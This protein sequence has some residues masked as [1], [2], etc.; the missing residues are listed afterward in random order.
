MKRTIKVHKKQPANHLIKKVYIIETANAT[1]II[2]KAKY[3][4]S[5]RSEKYYCKTDTS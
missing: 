4:A 5:L 3:R 1:P 2:A